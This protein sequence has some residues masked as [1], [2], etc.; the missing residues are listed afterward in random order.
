MYARRSKGVRSRENTQSPNMKRQKER[1]LR[2]KKEGGRILCLPLAEE[3]RKK[4]EQ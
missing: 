1:E 4:M 2:G 3:A